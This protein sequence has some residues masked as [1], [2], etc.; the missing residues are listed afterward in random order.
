VLKTFKFA[1]MSA[2]ASAARSNNLKM[3]VSPIDV[4]EKTEPSKLYL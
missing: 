1:M 3:Q 2:C 4:A